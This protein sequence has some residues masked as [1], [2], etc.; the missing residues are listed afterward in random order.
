MRANPGGWIT[1]DDVVGRD[2]LIRRLW[3]ILERNSLLLLAERRSGKT[4]V[5]RKMKSEAPDKTFTVYRDLQGVGT[6]VE[7][8]E[9]IYNDVEFLLST[10]RKAAEKVRKF[11]RHLVGAE[12]G[13][14][15]LPDTAARHWKNLLI[16]I[17]EDLMA[18][19]GGPTIFF[20]DEFPLMLF[21]IRRNTD[22]TTAMDVL[23]ALR[24]LRQN[25]P[26][27]RMVFTGSVGIYTVIDALK[28][29][30]YANDPT[31]DMHSVEMP[32][33]SDDDACR[34]VTELLEGEELLGEDAEEIEEIAGLVADRVNNN[35]YF[36][37]HIVDQMALNGE[38]TPEMIDSIILEALTGSQDHWH[39]RYY[40]DR[41]SIYYDLELLPWALAILDLLGSEKEALSFLEIIDILK[42][43][44]K[45]VDRELV[46]KVLNFLKRDLY[47]V[48]N[49]QGEYAFKTSIFKLFWRLNRPF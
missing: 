49:Q 35:P 3:R 9:S 17:V 29:A 38:C 20:W 39:L 43:S 8:V 19:R 48:L 13:F 26:D 34:L 44:K 12:L 42:E 36:I 41:L 23:D 14:F 30:G 46:L 47:L 2:L 18:S 25:C 1:P 31:N 37:H 5:I 28:Q 22:D 10:K 45:S 40:M 6:P 27:L 11:H 16:S 4:S 33:L 21:N 7:F 32:S 15:K 24:Y